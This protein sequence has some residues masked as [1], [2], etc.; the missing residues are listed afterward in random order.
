VTALGL[1][2]KKGR[3][4]NLTTFLAMLR[5]PVYIGTM[6]SKKWGMAKGL[7]RAIVSDRVF[8]DVQLILKGKKPVVAPYV[9]NREDFPLRRFLRCSECNR[10][11][12]GSPSRSRTG[13]LYDYYR[14]YNPEC[15]SIK[16]LRADEA[17]AKFLELL[18]RLR[19]DSSFTTEFSTTLKEEWAKRTVDNGEIVRNLRT[20]LQEIRLLQ[21]SLFTK[22]LKNDLNVVPRFEQMNRQYES[23]IEALEHQ[24]AIADMEKA[25]FED[26]LAFSKSMLVDIPK[27]WVMGN[28]DQKQKVQNV[29]FPSGLRYHREKGILNSDNDCL[30]NQ[31]EAFLGGKM[32]MVRPEGFEPP[33][34]WFV[35]KCS[36]QLS[37]GRTLR[38]TQPSKDIGIFGS[39][40]H[41]RPT[42]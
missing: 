21:D 32:N 40:Q 16:S 20:N 35:A 18:G 38:G 26:L 11:L 6:K 2:S 13:K 12:T 39:E 9:Q 30:F 8:S 17:T 33:T 5:N 37:Y 34:L 23:E 14:C 3:K 25:T 29:L 41:A 10:P 22:Y 1:R 4:L 27:A 7:H 19:V 28:V 31:L 42:P 15:R 24:I 36:I